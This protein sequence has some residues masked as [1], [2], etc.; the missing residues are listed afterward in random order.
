[1]INTRCD[2]RIRCVKGLLPCSG[3]KPWRVAEAAGQGWSD[4][5]QLDTWDSIL[6]CARMIGDWPAVPRGPSC[7]GRQFIDQQINVS[8]S[9]LR[10]PEA[11]LWLFER[12][13]N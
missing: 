10:I 1:M 11:L 4:G 2:G 12:I 6:E 8:S 13:T 7:D 5:D 3:L 9:K